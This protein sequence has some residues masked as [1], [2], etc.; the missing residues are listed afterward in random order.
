MQHAQKILARWN[1]SLSVDQHRELDAQLERRRFLHNAGK[2]SAAAIMLP[3]MALFTACDPSQPHAALTQEPWPTFAAVQ[4]VLF[5]NDG[6]GP[7]AN[8]LNAATYLHFVLNSEDIDHEE[9]DFIFKGI[10]WLNQLADTQHNKNFL[11]AGALQ[12][13]KL[14][15]TIAKSKSGERW[16]SYLLLYIFEALLSDPAYG[17]NPDGIGW[18]W[19]EHAPGFPRPDRQK[20]Y[21]NLL[22]R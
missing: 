14:I 7:S 15:E 21:P 9:R 6:N 5:P 17:G 3:S 19:L 11:A 18:S 16:L 20:T 12:Q 10:D 13:A 22:K 2:A 1:A 8:D 4:L